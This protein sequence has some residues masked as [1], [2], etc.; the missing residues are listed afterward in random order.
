MLF[1]IFV[2]VIFA[3]AAGAVVTTPGVVLATKLGRISGTAEMLRPED[4]HPGSTRFFYGFRGVPYAKP[5]VGHLRWKVLFHLFD[6]VRQL[7]PTL[8]WLVVV[9]APRPFGPWR[10]DLDATNFGSSC[11]QF[12]RSTGN[13]SGDEDCLSL[14]IFTPHVPIEGVHFCSVDQFFDS[15]LINNQFH[16][17]LNVAK[18]VMD[19][20]RG[21]LW[22]RWWYGS[23][24][25]VS[26]EEV[27]TSSVRSSLCERMSCS[28]PL[29][30]DWVSWVQDFSATV[31]MMTKWISWFVSLGF[32]STGSQHLPGNYGMLD[33]IEVIFMINCSA[34]F[35]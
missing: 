29:T 25:A 4:G 9:K 35:K 16:N 13:V 30:T 23:M 14:N 28:S 8:Y 20:G 24:A 11:P 2:V 10:S 32:L 5:P 15:S 31:K 34:P 17:S 26:S 19:R 18:L 27:R 7:I 22:C 3:A 12:E 6:S 1:V 33:V 21:R